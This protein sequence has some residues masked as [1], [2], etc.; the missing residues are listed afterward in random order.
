MK[1]I[2]E[3]ILKEFDKEFSDLTHV[4][5]RDKSIPCGT[6]QN[7]VVKFILKSIDQALSARDEEIIE[8]LKKM[9]VWS[10]SNGLE[11]EDIEINIGIDRA[12]NIINS[13]KQYE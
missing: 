10:T 3:E 11:K 4:S 7:D 12:I 1:N 8:Y 6:V 2:K 13:M 9:K 5:C